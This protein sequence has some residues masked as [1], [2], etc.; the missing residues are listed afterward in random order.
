MMMIIVMMMV[1]PSSMS[2]SHERSGCGSRFGGSNHDHEDEDVGF[3]HMR[4][5]TPSSPL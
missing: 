4:F 3:E 2:S 5:E 1:A